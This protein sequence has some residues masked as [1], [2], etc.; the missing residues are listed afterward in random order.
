MNKNYTQE[1]SYH[2]MLLDSAVNHNCIKQI[3]NIDLN[4]DDLITL[5][6]YGEKINRE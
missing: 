2:S 1:H 3:L 4:N 6:G 5:R